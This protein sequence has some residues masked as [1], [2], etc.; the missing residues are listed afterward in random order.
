MRVSWLSI[1]KILRKIKNRQGNTQM[2]T[3]VFASNN[4]S[5]IKEVKSILGERFGILSMKE[6][7]LDLDIDETGATFEENAILKAKA[8]FNMLKL[9]SV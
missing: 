1:K 2:K 8:V 7:G 6:A 9:P 5:K 3:I 4:E